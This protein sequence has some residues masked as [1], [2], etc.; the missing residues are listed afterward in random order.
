MQGKA[1]IKYY[2]LPRRRP[3]DCTSGNLHVRQSATR[4]AREQWHCMLV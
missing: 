2:I 1:G 4:G 3:H